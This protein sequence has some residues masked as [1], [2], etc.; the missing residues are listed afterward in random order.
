MSSFRARGWHVRVGK[1]PLWI[2]VA[3]LTIA[4]CSRD[5]TTL[6]TSSPRWPDDIL[7]P[8]LSAS[9]ASNGTF[10]A[11]PIVDEGLGSLSL[12]QFRAL[13]RG[14]I[15]SFGELAVGRWRRDA[16]V[17]IES[18]GLR[19]CEGPYLSRSAY[20]DFSNA[21]GW[22]LRHMLGPRYNAVYCDPTSG[23]AV[24]FSVSALATGHSA[25]ADGRLR[26]GGDRSLGNVVYSRALL[27]DG[28]STALVPPEEAASIAASVTGSRVA[29][30]PTLFSP[31]FPLS[32]NQAMWRIQLERAVVAFAAVGKAS[33]SLVETSVVFV[34]VLRSSHPTGGVLVGADAEWGLEQERLVVES[35]APSSSPD[36]RLSV[37]ALIP[38][39]FAPA[40]FSQKE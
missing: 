15:R 17:L 14:H 10:A 39:G 27:P 36:S 22:P 20:V 8:D 16:G 9:L 4:S 13:V 7:T 21:S 29:A 30:R 26:E 28:E 25:H 1:A 32:P 24:Y 3:A 37:H 12:S 38:S 35:V 6:L 34:P 19:L 40:H 23:A 11:E 31:R 2:A 18:A 33:E 5:Q